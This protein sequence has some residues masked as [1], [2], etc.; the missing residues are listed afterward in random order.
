[1]P[2]ATAT[3]LCGAGFLQGSGRLAVIRVEF[4]TGR[5]AESHGFKMEVGRHRAAGC[6]LAAAQRQRPWR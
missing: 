5:R 6:S 3:T 4:H 1:M 2:W